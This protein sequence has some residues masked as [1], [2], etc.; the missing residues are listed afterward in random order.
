[1]QK[2]ISLPTRVIAIVVTYNPDAGDLLNLLDA[3][4]PQ[5]ES[6][7]V[8]DNASSSDVSSILIRLSGKNVELLQ[9]Q[10]NLGVAAAQNAG[11]ERA[12]KLDADFVLFSDQDSIPSSSM[13]AEL[14]AVFT[15]AC[16][17]PTARPVAAVGP[18]TV[19]RRTGRVSFFVIMRA[20]IPRMWQPPSDIKN[21]PRL[22]D[23]EFLIASGTLIPI[24]VIRRVGAMRSNYFIDHVDTE[25]CFR[26]K[27][28]GYRLLGVPTSRLDHKLGDA[29]KRV[30]FFG[31]RQVMFHSPLRDYYMFRNTVQML[32]DTSMTWTWRIHFLWRLAQFAGY[33]LLFAGQRWL[34][35]RGMTLGLLHAFRGIS[36]CLETKTSQCHAIPRSILEPKSQE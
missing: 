27:A 10:G 33:F 20:G 17:H 9:M 30:W 13:V 4:L 36:G 21:F 3:L 2:S 29:V 35:F 12:I 6:V 5:V 23:V 16:S 15:S 7:V 31:Y 18:A 28:A 25:W 24:D 1:M 14:I 19:D 34:R 22:I 26:A 11:V 32:R 8:V